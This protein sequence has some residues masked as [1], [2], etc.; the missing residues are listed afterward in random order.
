MVVVAILALLISVLLP[1]LTEAVRAVKRVKCASNLKSIGNAMSIYLSESDGFYPNSGVYGAGG[2]QGTDFTQFTLGSHIPPQ[3][4]PLNRHLG[5]DE[6]PSEV[7]RCPGDG[8]DVYFE[9][10]SFFEAHGTSYSY[11]GNPQYGAAAHEKL[12]TYGIEP[13]VEARLEDNDVLTGQGLPKADSTNVAEIKYSDKKIVF[14]EPPLNPD[15]SKRGGGGLPSRDFDISDQA[16][17]HS[18]KDFHSNALFA[19]GHVEFIFLS[20]NVRDGSGNIRDP[21]S[22]AVIPSVKNGYY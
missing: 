3:M 14:H 18:H 12:N 17:W 9:L 8:G 11:A 6:D 22:D 20:P 5:A 7:F 2:N 4:R 21:Y 19:D 10:P 13:L 16:H 15:F 1:S